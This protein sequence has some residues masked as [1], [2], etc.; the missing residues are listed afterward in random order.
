MFRFLLATTSILTLLV[1]TMFLP[2]SAAARRCDERMPLTLLA[3]YR[4]SESIYIGK[5]E[6]T[7]DG[8]PT[9]DTADY[10]AVP[11]TKH[12][13][14]SSSL[15]GES[16]KLLT[17]GDTEY[18]YK[19][20]ETVEEEP[21]HG[22]DPE[23]KLNKGDTVLLFLKKNEETATI[24]PVEISDG[25]KKMTPEKLSSYEARIR[26]LNGIFASEKPKYARIVDWL[27]RCAEDPQTRWEGTFDLLLSFQNM[28][29]MDERA[30]QAKE[31]PVEP[32]TADTDEYV[33][34]TPKE[35]ES[36]DPNFARAVSDGDKSRLTSILLNRE[37]PAKSEDPDKE[38]AVTHGDREL[39]ELVKR[40][41][42][43]KVAANLL[44]QLRHD[45]S[46]ATQNSELMASIATMLHDDQLTSVSESYANIQWESEEDEVRD[47]EA[48]AVTE[49][50]DKPAVDAP[51]VTTP[52]LPVEADKPAVEAGA[53]ETPKKKTYGEMR[54]ELIAKFVDRAGKL[55][56]KEENKNSAKLNR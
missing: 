51:A 26:E 11:I 4:S 50:A 27:I 36:G 19:N 37:R 18:R 5:Y 2:V 29:W 17:L 56:A 52:E 20:V 38:T 43:S 13:S 8:E 10:I 14:I 30:K 21:E 40:W 54:S 28:D 24:E 53:S 49:P 47:E 15:K 7:V 46:D 34:E 31:K 32:G 22:D 44:E 9:E 45:T 39:I 1:T 55:I 12:F 35:F 23:I 3:L 48:P 6:K 25:I 42:D 16:R 33:P 41:G